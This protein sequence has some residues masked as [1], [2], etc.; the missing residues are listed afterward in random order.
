MLYPANRPARIAAQAG[1]REFWQVLN[2]AADTYFDLELRAGPD[3]HNAPYAV[4]FDIIGRDGSPNA[5]ESVTH[6]LIPPGGRAEFVFTMPPD[7]VFAQLVTDRYDAGPAGESMP[8]RVLVNIEWQG[9]PAVRAPAAG[10]ISILGPAD[11]SG[12][13]PRMPFLVISPYA[14]VNYVDHN[15]IDQ[16]SVVCFIEDTFALGRIGAP[17]LDSEAGQ[18]TQMFNFSVAAPAV[19]LDPTQGTVVSV[20]SNSGST[21]SGTTG[22]GTGAGSGSSGSGVTS[23]VAGPKNFRQGEHGDSASPIRRRPGRIHFCP[24]GDGRRRQDGD[25]HGHDLRS[26]VLP[27][28]SPTARRRSAR[29]ALLFL[30]GSQG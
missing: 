3:I 15:V 19:I 12:Y 2:A 5:P 23:A 6:V 20:I 4:H 16:S 11:L 28:C 10:P 30:A 17:S 22:T 8:F 1:R 27:T 21:G 14:K 29:R 9:Q 13:G 7:S 26:V 24:D 18:I 25:R